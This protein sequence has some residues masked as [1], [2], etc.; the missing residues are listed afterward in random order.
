MTGLTAKQGL[1][2]LAQEHNAVT[3]TRFEP[4][5]PRSRVKH[6]TTEPLR[7]L[8]RMF[9]LLDKTMSTVYTLK[10]P[11]EMHY[12]NIIILQMRHI[13]SVTSWVIKCPGSAG[14]LW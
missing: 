8:K 1:M 13:A 9:K 5:I 3:Q 14:I 7:S 11:M 6:S 10:S 4:A 2:S 12:G